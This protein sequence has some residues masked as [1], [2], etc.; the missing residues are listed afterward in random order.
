MKD[1]KSKGK[2]LEKNRK[3]KREVKNSNY[4]PPTHPIPSRLLKLIS[5]S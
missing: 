3:E 5:L 4:I 2:V 1:G